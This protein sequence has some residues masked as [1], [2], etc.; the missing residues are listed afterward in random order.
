MR[1]NAPL[2]TG[3]ILYLVR[4]LVYSNEYNTRYLYYIPAIN[5]NSSITEART[6]HCS[7]IV[8]TCRLRIVPSFSIGQLTCRSRESELALLPI[9]RVLL[10]V[11]V[12]ASEQSSRR[13]KQ[14]LESSSSSSSSRA[15]KTNIRITKKTGTAPN[16]QQRQLRRRRKSDSF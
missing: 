1:S 6:I 2:R 10:D 5:S 11:T 13:Y 3:M 15:A 7:Y 14:S 16:K 4:V 8:A 9:L 12:R